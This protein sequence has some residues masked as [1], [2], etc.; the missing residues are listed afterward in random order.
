MRT[1]HQKQPE[2]PPSVGA[3]LVDAQ[4]HV[5]HWKATAAVTAAPRRWRDAAR[6][7]TLPRDPQA[8]NASHVAHWLSALGLAQYGTVFEQNAITGE[9]LLDL[10]D[11]E[12]E[13]AL[14][15]RIL[16]HRKLLCKSIDHL[17]AT[18]SAD[19]LVAL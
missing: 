1:H 9:S 16:G 6:Q 13:Q 12:L 4:P 7:R 14:H 2:P 8:W 3:S 15:I 11:R 19:V 5:S 18:A 10:S 17:K